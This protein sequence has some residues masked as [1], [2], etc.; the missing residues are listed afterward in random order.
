LEHDDLVPVTPLDYDD[1]REWLVEK[2]GWNLAA[3][4]IN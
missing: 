3:S 1:F 2:A 4:P